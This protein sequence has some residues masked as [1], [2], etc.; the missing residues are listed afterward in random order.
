V[1]LF[2]FRLQIF[3]ELF[4][5][6]LHDA[7]R[8][9][10]KIEI[11]ILEHALS[12]GM[13]FSTIASPKIST[14]LAFADVHKFATTG[15]ERTIHNPFPRDPRPPKKR[16]HEVLCPKD[17]PGKV[18]R[19]PFCVN[20]EHPSGIFSRRA[21]HDDFVRVGQCPAATLFHHIA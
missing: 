21:A 6:R 7:Q 9:Y 5:P 20:N 16:L 12:L 4:P 17:G 11:P 8:L 1:P 13:E 3:C 10:G 2:P 18:L 14:P 19:T 15:A